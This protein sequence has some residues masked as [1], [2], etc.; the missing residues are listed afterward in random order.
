MRLRPSIL[1][2]VTALLAAAC[3]PPAPE[4]KSEATIELPSTPSA[5]ATVAAAEQ[6]LPAAGAPSPSARARFERLPEAQRRAYRDADLIVIA[7]LDQPRIESILEIAPPIYVHAFDVVTDRRLAGGALP[8]RVTARLSS[9][10]IS[11]PFAA[12]QPMI[13]ALR[14]VTA[15]LEEAT[16]Y[17]EALSVAPATD[18]LADA[19]ASARTTV[20]ASLSWTVA[21]VPPANPQHWSN[22]YGDGEFDLTLRN[23]GAAPIT[24]PGLYQA[25]GVVKLSEAIVVRDETGRALPVSKRAL[26]DG[27]TPVTLAPGA[28]L[29]TRVDVKPFGIVQPAGGSRFIYSFAIGELR[30]S[31][32]FY[33]THTLHGPQMGKV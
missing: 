15:T 29:T 7:H 22:D 20:D 8:G 25:G 26:P 32:F 6:E 2:V 4:A 3:A 10:A 27:A 18:E 14:R 31:S 21:Q 9:Q 12:K 1:V 16:T 13:V 11:E 33:Y 17:Y 23:D 28:T 19:I 24:V 5:A 30:T